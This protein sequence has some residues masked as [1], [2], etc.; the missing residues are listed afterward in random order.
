VLRDRLGQTALAWRGIDA[1]HG[2]ACLL[3]CLAIGGFAHRRHRQSTGRDH[4][5]ASAQSDRAL[6]VHES[7]VTMAIGSPRTTAHLRTPR[8]AAMAGLPPYSCWLRFCFCAWPFRPTR[9][10]PAPGCGPTPAQLRW[11]Y[12][13]HAGDGERG[14]RRR[15]SVRRGEDHRPEFRLQ[16][17][18]R[19]FP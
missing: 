1:D 14:N 9:A 4:S 13:V 12:I 6:P 16:L 19:S 15:I 18:D 3:S 8:A 2:Q 7:P 10:K 17:L 11:H 5:R